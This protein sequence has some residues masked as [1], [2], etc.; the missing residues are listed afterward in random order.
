[1]K[2]LQEMLALI[3]HGNHDV[4][5]FKLVEGIEPVKTISKFAYYRESAVTASLKKKLEK[6]GKEF[7]VTV[8][9]GKPKADRFEVEKFV[10]I[11]LTGTRNSIKQVAAQAGLQMNDDSLNEAGRTFTIK[12]DKIKPR[13]A[14]ED[15]ARAFDKVNPKTGTRPDRSVLGPTGKSVGKYHAVEFADEEDYISV[16]VMRDDIEYRDS[17]KDPNDVYQG[18]H[19]VFM[20]NGKISG[21]T[22]DITSKRQWAADKDKI[23]AAAKAGLKDENLSH[24]YDGLGGKE[25]KRGKGKLS[26]DVD[27]HE[28]DSNKKMH[29]H[30]SDEGMSDA[31]RLEEAKK[32]S[33]PFGVKLGGISSENNHFGFE[34][35][36]NAQKT[37][38]ALKDAGIAFKR[39][40]N[41]GIFYFDFESAADL[42]K[43]VKIVKSVI[44]KSVESE[45]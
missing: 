19:V 8:T 15:K 44:D 9:Y 34:D 13:G 18:I 28:I 29:R 38:S 26:F 2:L 5:G 11:K 22:L 21:D 6:A 40:S 37:E 14:P 12:N 39:H 30:R 4:S 25:V 1:M 3:E 33:A 7:D 31:K 41:F 35:R 27:N 43:A 10:N 23:V 20:P 42:K 24:Y 32:R 45:W 16:L 17:A 36:S